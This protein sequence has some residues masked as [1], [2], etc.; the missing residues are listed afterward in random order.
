[1]LAGMAKK[2]NRGSQDGRIGKPIEMPSPWGDLAE[3]LGSVAM[4]DALGVTLRTL[5]RWATGEMKP[6]ALRVPAIR[7]LFAK[8]KIKPPC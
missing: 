1:M 4:A 2:V 6:H 7:K 3:V 5:N 8:H